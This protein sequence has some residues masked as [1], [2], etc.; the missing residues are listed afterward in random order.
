MLI[1][2]TEKSER[3]FFFTTRKPFQERLDWE[4]VTGTD[5]REIKRENE[6]IGKTDRKTSTTKK[7]AN[8]QKYKMWKEKK[9]LKK[10]KKGD[11]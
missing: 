9:R 11:K 10:N 2:K 8:E 1:I 7:K 5:K 6:I 3:N 4:W